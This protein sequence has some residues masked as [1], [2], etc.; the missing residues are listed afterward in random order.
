MQQLQIVKKEVK[1]FVSKLEIIN[2]YNQIEN[3]EW[4]NLNQPAG[5]QPYCLYSYLSTKFNNTV[6]LD[7]GTRRGNSAL[8][9]SYNE[10]NKVI[11]FDLIK[12]EAIEFIKKDNIEFRIGDFMQDETIDYNNVSIIMI[13]VD[14][15][16][17]IQEPPMIK[18]LEDKGW[19]GL[20]ILDDTSK[21]L[22]PAIHNMFEQL[23]YEKYDL[24]DIGHFSGTGLINFGK[25]F[26]IEII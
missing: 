15:H 8:S 13:D 23:P 2:K 16:D 1:D 11:S 24:T 4:D 21:E 22:W 12:Y 3:E 25:K 20:L 7:I 5:D 6:I 17:G 10:N 14:P 18:F 9:L 19:S 26:E